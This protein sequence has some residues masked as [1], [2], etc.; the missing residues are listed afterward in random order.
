ME[1]KVVGKNTEGLCSRCGSKMVLMIEK[2][3]GSNSRKISY[4]YKCTGCGFKKSGGSIV[5]AKINGRIRV[6]VVKDKVN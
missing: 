1:L 3:L 5:I 4:I 2:T 6:S